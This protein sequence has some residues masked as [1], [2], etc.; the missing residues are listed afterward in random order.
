MVREYSYGRKE[1]GE[2]N[3]KR[4][5]CVNMKEMDKRR[6]ERIGEMIHK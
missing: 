3:R 2:R 5:Y 1:I 4:N 6:K